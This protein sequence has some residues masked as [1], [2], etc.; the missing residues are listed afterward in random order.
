MVHYV[1]SLRETLPLF[2]Y[3]ADVG[4]YGYAWS[5]IKDACSYPSGVH[6]C[7]TQPLNE[8]HLHCVRYRVAPLYLNKNEFE[9]IRI[10]V[11]VLYVFVQV[12]LLCKHLS[13]GAF[14]T[15]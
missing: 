9:T 2:A 7:I 3:T 6:Y 12:M 14:R 4:L 13:L 1:S 5:I 8:G 10:F 11:R 15:Q